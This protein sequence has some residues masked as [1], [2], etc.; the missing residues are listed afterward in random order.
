M[1]NKEIIAALRKFVAKRSGLDWRN[2]YCS[3]ADVDG[4]KAYRAD[5][6][7]IA[8]DGKHARQLLTLCELLKIPL[9]RLVRSQDRLNM[10]VE[11]ASVEYTTGQYF[12]TEY[13]AAVCR[14]CASAIWDWLIN[15]ER[16]R[17]RAE[18]QAWIKA[19]LGRGIANA[20]FN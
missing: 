6:A 1:E 19:R 12:P 16:A 18:V 7:E 13:R 14:A 11:T 15:T 10:N 17:N 8:K 4:V 3:Y 9:T 20:W 2:Y 5:R